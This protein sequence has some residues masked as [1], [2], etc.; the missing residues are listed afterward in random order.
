MTIIPENYNELISSFNYPGSENE[1]LDV[2]CGVMGGYP[3]EA[4]LPW[5]N[6]IEQSGFTG[7]KVMI[8]YFAEISLV[9]KLRE[10]GWLVLCF[11]KL[12]D[13]NMYIYNTAGEY[14]PPNYLTGK[15]FHIC[16]D[17]FYHLW[18]FLSKLPE[19]IK[20]RCRYITATDVKDIIFQSNPFTWL[21][22]NLQ[23]GKKIVAI[24]E[25]ITYG[26]ETNFGA[27]NLTECFG[28]KM[29]EYMKE[30]LIY[31]A[32]TMAG[33]FNTMVDI[34]LQIYMMSM[35][36][37][38]KHLQ[39]DQAAYNILLSLAPYKNITQYMMSEDG[40]AA[41]LG[42]CWSHKM[43]EGKICEPFPVLDRSSQLLCTSKNKPY[44]IVHQYD[45]I[46]ELAQLFY[47]KYAFSN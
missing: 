13:R 20:S 14:S 47:P 40:W 1:P 42:T 27:R 12:L 25:S 44:V 7:L 29:F 23:D 28:D 10:R 5:V 16:V 6:S 43:F 26:N 4:I 2:F 8:I 41:Q 18:F 46:P 39:P 34:F 15:Q 21:E 3:Y 19:H 22:N 45:R 32:G 38:I 36:G 30:R 24:T 11:D 33:E 9:Q 35:G 17:R 37:N 31:N